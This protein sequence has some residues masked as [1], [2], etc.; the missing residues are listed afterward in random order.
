MQGGDKENYR[1]IGTQLKQREGLQEGVVGKELG[2]RRESV[3]SP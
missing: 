1:V 2:P 3:I